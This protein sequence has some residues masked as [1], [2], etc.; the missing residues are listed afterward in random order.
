MSSITPMSKNF[1]DSVEIGKTWEENSAIIKT[2]LDKRPRY[3]QLCDEVTYIL[4]KQLHIRNIEYSAITSRA[5][6]LPS[7]VE[8]LSR[9]HYSN[10]LIDI[11]DLAGVRIVY[12]YKSDSHAIE[13]TIDE[14]FEIVERVDRSKEQEPDRFGY[15]AI[16][17]VVRLGGN[18]SGARYDDLKGL[19]CEIQV[20]TV[21]QDAWAILNHH[22]SY[23]Q[24]AD[25]PNDLRREIYG[26]AALMGTA[27]TTFERVRAERQNYKQKITATVNQGNQFLNED[28]N[29][30]TFT[31]FLDWKFPMLP[32]GN[33]KLSR[34]LD[35]LVRYGYKSLSDLEGLLTRTETA[36]NAIAAEAKTVFAA[37]E[38]ARAIGLEQPAYRTEEAWN[39]EKRA[40][41]AKYEGL[42]LKH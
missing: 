11:T 29:L 34:V 16:H 32:M 18:S 27:D 41:F 7:F 15:A 6:T 24:E 20:R 28:L 25:V 17:Y 30:D 4:R 26:L 5:K 3:E 9:K 39:D 13:N 1:E 10:A 40:L 21:F 14:N 42:I 36:R 8:K 12:L 35:A 38:I 33:R 22:L 19:L 23:K 2:F 37:G 31:V